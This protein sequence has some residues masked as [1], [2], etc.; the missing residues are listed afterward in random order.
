MSDARL[1]LRASTKDQDPKRAEFAMHE[2]AGRHS[3]QILATYTDVKSGTRLERPE[4]GRLLQDAKHGEIL[5]CESVDRLSR[6]ER[7]EWKQ[8]RNMID[9]KGMRL[10]IADLPTTHVLI[11]GHDFGTQ[12]FMIINDLILDIAATQ[13]RIDQETRTTRIREGL[14]NKARRGEKVGGKGRNLTKWAAIQ[15]RLSENLTVA[16]IAKLCDV[17]IATVYRVKAA[18]SKSDNLH[19]NKKQTV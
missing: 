17:G 10:V 8:L 5:L 11:G 14:A 15:K 6:L 12:I 3:I 16:D 18:S 1:Y 19:N 7:K 9:E 13:A 4:L 2:F